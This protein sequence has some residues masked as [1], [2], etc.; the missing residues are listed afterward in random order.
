MSTTE[1]QRSIY[2]FFLSHL[3]SMASFTRSDLQ[4]VTTWA[5]SAFDTYWSKQFKPFIVRRPDGTFRMSE[6]FRPFSTWEKFQKHVTQVRRLASSDYQHAVYDL[7]RIYEFFMP[8]SNEEHLRTAL[9]ALFYRDRV[10]ARLRTIDPVAIRRQFPAEDKENDADYLER[11]CD[12]ISDTFG[13]YSVY[14]VDGRFRAA[15]LTDRA[16]AADLP[17]YL[18]DET[19]AVTR[20]IFPCKNEQHSRLVEF[21]FAELFVQAIV[22]VVNA[23]DEIWMTETGMVNR[24]HV[25]RLDRGQNDIHH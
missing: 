18:V 17:R 8:L 3:S 25:W 2:E 24:L 6:A 14:H 4:T 1:N 10:R 23:E 11:L 5:D 19:T 20:F 12:W 15:A 16:L 7:V 13:G 9:D 21:L 22:E